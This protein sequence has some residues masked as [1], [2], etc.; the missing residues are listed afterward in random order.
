MRSMP[1]R[2]LGVIG[3]GNMGSAIL[4]G[5]I[6]AGL[7]RP[8]EV[9]ICDLVAEKAAGLASEL[10]INLA[11]TASDAARAAS[12][13]L[14]AVKPQTMGECLSEVGDIIDGSRLVISIAAGISTEFIEKRVRPNARVVRAMPNTPA[15]VGAGATAICG[16]T[17]AT[18]QD[19]AE[20]ELLFGA[21][22]K[23]YRVDESLMD[24]VTAVSGSGPAYLFLFAECLERAALACGLPASETGDLVTQ[25]LFGASKLL[26]E[27][28]E[29]PSV[30]RA[31]VT[32]PGGTTEA[33]IAAFNERG[34][35]EI[36][37]TAVT[38]ALERARE[39][40]GVKKR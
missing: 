37:R 2:K 32:S 38:S 10:K 36:V 23:V 13:V 22:G 35:D 1:S 4:R 39:L 26:R 8:D 12:T 3:V 7:F 16:G 11:R 34:L 30:L 29:H 33:A 6:K 15:L 28:D 24:A 18:P 17:H 5:V 9:T 40:G 25:T 19:L 14:L 31:R 27:S 21:L 20:A